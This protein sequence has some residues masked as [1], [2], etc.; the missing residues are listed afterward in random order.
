[1]NLNVELTQNGN[2]RVFKT[3][4]VHTLLVN[5]LLSENSEFIISSIFDINDKKRTKVIST[6]CKKLSI[7][8]KEVITDTWFYND[9]TLLTFPLNTKDWSD[10]FYLLLSTHF[11]LTGSHDSNVC[12]ISIIWKKE[13]ITSITDIIHKINWLELPVV[14]QSYDNVDIIEFF[15]NEKDSYVQENST[16]KSLSDFR[17]ILPW[18]YPD[19]D[20][21]LLVDSFLES[22]EN[23]LV[24]LWEP[25]TWKTTF[26][27]YLMK[28][29]CEKQISN[30][31]SYVKD[32]KLL[33]RE[34][35]WMSLKDYE[36]K[37]VVLDD[38]DNGLQPRK[39]GSKDSVNF[40][41]KL[42]SFSDWL[43]ENKTKIIITSNIVLSEIDSAIIRPGRCFDI[44]NFK[45]LTYV[46]AKHVWEKELK[47]SSFDLYFPKEQYTTIS[48][49]SLMSKYKEYQSTKIKRTYLKNPEI[50]LKK[51]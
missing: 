26:V 38:L 43:F 17:E 45:H 25:G 10:K 21:D 24:L 4:N 35:L 47:S 1:M 41:N 20:L 33:E 44:L 9:Y 31:I 28:K 22:D 37:V 7:S 6:I 2:G 13:I 46:Q 12:W 18:L 39:T 48:Q 19:I 36:S 5:S 42:L 30:S 32:E 29:I 49:A 23:I 34:Q 15:W 11:E 50:S 27:K 16:R 3:W 14:E 40:V 51:Q 8:Q